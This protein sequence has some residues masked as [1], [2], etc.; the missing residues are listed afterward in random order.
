MAGTLGD[1]V[2]ELLANDESVPAAVDEAALCE[3]FTL[4]PPDLF[5]F[6]WLVLRRTD[7]YRF[8]VSPPLGRDWPNRTGWNAWV[9]TTATAWLDMLLNGGAPPADLS[10][11]L[12]QIRAALPTALADLKADDAGGHWDLVCALVS[13]HAV[14]DA[15]TDG[16]GLPGS[17]AAAGLAGPLARLVS[18]GTL[19]RFSPDLVRV[20]PRMRTPQSGVSL[21]SLSQNLSAIDSVVDVAWHVQNETIPSKKTALNVLVLPWPLSVDASTFKPGN[22]RL[23]NIDH[24]KFGF[25]DFDPPG[26][27][28]IEW[29]RSAIAWARR[30]VRDVDVIV[31][32]EAALRETEHRALCVAARAAGVPLVLS[33]L[34]ADY[35]NT[36]RLSILSDP[37]SD[38]DLDQHKH[39]RWKVE[40]S[41]IRNYA[42][43][44][45]LDPGLQWWERID[46]HRRSLTFHASNDW[47]TTCHLICED[48]ARVEPVSEVIRAVGPTL[49]VA[50]L[51]DGP[52]LKHRWSARYA[53][54]FADDPGCSVLSCTSLGMAERSVPA[55]GKKDRTIAIWS[56]SNGLHPLELPVD[57]DALLLTLRVE[58]RE[59]FSADGRPDQQRAAHLLLGQADPVPRCRPAAEPVA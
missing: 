48:L 32:P 12:A 6:T 15:T 43:A 4:S 1:L 11:L 29:A 31:L 44:S 55:G 40:S 42:I 38:L 18:R 52:Q 53:S 54:V 45:S 17:G 41:Q 27:F 30:R 7:A 51:Q 35:Q 56:D 33:G 50:L 37:A 39:H 13:L 20:L 3:A 26:S 16:L 59:E 19:A 36:A 46:I 2:N 8:V 10:A 57:H 49:L 24:T 28:D 47:L 58:W 21:N 22:Y 14:A 5:A 23:D 9:A 25:F 34:R